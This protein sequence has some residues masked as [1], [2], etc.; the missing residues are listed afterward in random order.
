[1]FGFF[2]KLKPTRIIKT[3][4]QKE[5]KKQLEQCMKNNTKAIIG[6]DIDEEFDLDEFEEIIEDPAI[7]VRD[8]YK[9]GRNAKC[10]CGSNK[11]YK[12]CCLRF[13]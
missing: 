6:M 3:K 9:I 8:K 1:L 12:K 2:K 4:D 7:T 13:Q 5:A 11:K 10:L